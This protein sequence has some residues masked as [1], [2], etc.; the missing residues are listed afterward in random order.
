MCGSGSLPVNS[1][2]PYNT[3]TDTTT[4]VLDFG[5][6]LTGPGTVNTSALTESTNCTVNLSVDNYSN[7][8]LNNTFPATQEEEIYIT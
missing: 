8:V 4:T 1:P 2:A 3:T 6:G 7:G 5:P